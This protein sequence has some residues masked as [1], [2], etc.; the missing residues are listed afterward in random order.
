VN[1]AFELERAGLAQT[2]AREP[3]I[4]LCAPL[5]FADRLGFVGALIG[6]ASH[7]GVQF[8]RE[9]LDAARV[10]SRSVHGSRFE[11]FF[12]ASNDTLRL[13]RLDPAL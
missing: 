11:R 9:E 13:P 2:L 7:S 5:E 6:M 4:D 8:S 12:V 3:A 1:V 10:M